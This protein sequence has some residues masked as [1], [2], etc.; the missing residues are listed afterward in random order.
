VRIASG[1]RDFLSNDWMSKGNPAGINAFGEKSRTP[2][3]MRT[4]GHQAQET[5]HH[6]PIS[7]PTICW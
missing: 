4:Q 2:E 7:Q 1:V 6:P 3:A 5:Q